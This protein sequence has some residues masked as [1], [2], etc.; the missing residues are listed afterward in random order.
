MGEV[1]QD[2]PFL[3]MKLALESQSSHAF[4]IMESVL[5]GNSLE[6]TP[7]LFSTYFAIFV[8]W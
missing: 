1:F 5:K 4:I 8:R 6:I 2:S 3:A 7:F